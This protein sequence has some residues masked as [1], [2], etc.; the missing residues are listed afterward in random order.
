LVLTARG[1]KHTQREKYRSGG[2]TPLNVVVNSVNIR[3][4]LR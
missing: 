2:D 1:M 3:R 4:F